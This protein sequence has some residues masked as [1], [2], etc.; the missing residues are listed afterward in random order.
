MKSGFVYRLE[1]TS[2]VCFVGFTDVSNNLVSRLEFF[3]GPS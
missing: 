1:W 2:L 3:V